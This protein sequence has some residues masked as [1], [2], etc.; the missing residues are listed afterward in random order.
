MIIFKEMW[1]LQSPTFLRPRT[2]VGLEVGPHV[3]C[4]I[5]DS[6]ELPGKP[7]DELSQEQNAQHLD[8]LYLDDDENSLLIQNFTQHYYITWLRDLT[9]RELSESYDVRIFQE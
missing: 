7:T 1:I 5:E 6:E 2:H 9:V 8:H 3:G 4:F